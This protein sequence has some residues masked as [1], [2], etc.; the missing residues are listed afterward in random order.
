MTT[1]HT[2]S[3]LP[4]HFSTEDF[5]VIP[6]LLSDADLRLQQLAKD[7]Q[8]DLETLNYPDRNWDYS[9][10]DCLEVAI[11]GGGYAGKSAAFGLRRHGI[12]N[13]CM[14]DRQPTGQEGPWRTFAHNATLRTPKIVTGGLDWGIANLNF[15]RWCAACYGDDYWQR[16]DYIPRLM[17]ADYLDW[18]GHVLNLPLQSETD[19]QNITWSEAEQCFWLHATYQEQPTLYKARFVIFATGLECTGGKQVPSIVKNN[20]PAHCYHHT[21]D[22]IDFTAFAQQ[23]VVI[24]GGG[25]SAFDHAILL[26][27]S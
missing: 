19:I 6:P 25:A 2:P 23:R 11:I 4:E 10:G 1:I 5:W 17:W 18:Y 27:E 8:T 24:I 26:L 9:R 7:I 22:S 21:M 13:V 20:L 12:P 3:P 16:I 15:R 14:F